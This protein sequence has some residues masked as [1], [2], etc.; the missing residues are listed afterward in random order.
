MKVIY[1]QLY[2]TQGGP[3]PTPLRIWADK[4][5]NRQMPTGN[6]M[7]LTQKGEVVGEF[8]PGTIQGWW[9]QDE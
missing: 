6:K 5:E 3:A 9:L 2:A 8:E 4:I 7:V 1:V